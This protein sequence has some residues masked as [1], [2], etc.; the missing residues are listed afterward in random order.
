MGL[1]Y[2]WYYYLIIGTILLTGK[3]IA[4]KL[5]GMHHN[6]YQ[7]GYSPTL[8]RFR[9]FDVTFSIGIVIPIPWLFKIYE[10]HD[11]E[12]RKPTPIWRKREYPFTKRLG[13]ILG[14]FVMLYLI[15]TILYAIS[16]YTTNRVYLSID[17]V[18]EN[19]IYVD[20]TG[21]EL[22]FRTGD[23]ILKIEGKSYE[24]FNDIKKI[25]LLNKAGHFTINRNDSV[26]ELVIDSNKA[27]QEIISQKSE[28]FYPVF[29]KY[30]LRVESVIPISYAYDAGIKKG[31]EIIT[32]N[33]DT[34]FFYR[35]FAKSIQLNRNKAV[36]LGIRR[37]NS[38]DL[39]FMDVQKD[40]YGT[41]GINIE[42]TLKRTNEKK[43]L[44]KSL[45]AGNV[46]MSNYF[47]QMCLIFGKEETVK[48]NG[49]FVTL[50]NVFPEPFPFLRRISIILLAY[51]CIHIIPSPIT[52]TRFL[53]ALLLDQFIKLPQNASIW[54]GWIVLVP[55]VLY[56]SIMDLLKIF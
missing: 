50:G 3:A 23:E 10:I 38:N 15:A 19:G 32:V 48:R 46:F 52:D 35:D 26:Q 55:M 27:I 41:I 16:Y 7:I 49:G 43:S 21:Y 1:L 51:I 22:G 53:I 29:A 34:T 2:L 42:E 17:N 20:S 25:M 12:K 18:N 13:G 5:L 14:G 45:N 56:T 47:N 40:E 37:N 28:L 31:D 33:N 44:L 36:Q 30:P 6:H 11:N 54:I 39:I 8:C 9:L 24:R 4:C